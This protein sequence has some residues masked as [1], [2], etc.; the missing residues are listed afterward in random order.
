MKTLNALIVIAALAVGFPTSAVASGDALASCLADNTTG[1]DRKDLARWI[2][3][4]M[5]AHPDIKELSKATSAVSEQSSRHM[6]ALVSRLLTESCKDELKKLA[7]DERRQ[8]LRTAF[9]Y[10]GKVAMQ[11]L[12]NNQDVNKAISE[13]EQ[14]LDRAKFEAAFKNDK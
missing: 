12:M 5:A 4:A 13:F 14:Y 6:A 9:E 8:S 1:K 7:D 2:F 11:E 3:L 10:L